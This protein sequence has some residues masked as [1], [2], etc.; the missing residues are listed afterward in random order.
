MQLWRTTGKS[1]DVGTRH[2]GQRVMLEARQLDPHHDEHHED[3]LVT[4]MLAS[5]ATDMA[6]SPVTAF[7]RN[8]SAVLSRQ[9]MHAV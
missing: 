8:R 4:V 2:A 6:S 1:A 9:N 3:I 5:S 7:G